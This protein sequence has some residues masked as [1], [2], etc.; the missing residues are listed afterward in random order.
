MKMNVRTPA[1]VLV[2]LGMLSGCATLSG[3]DAK[4]SFKC[5]ASGGISCESASQ[6]YDR[7][8]VGNLPGL[9]KAVSPVG[10]SSVPSKGAAVVAG[11]QAIALPV[12]GSGAGVSTFAASTP[13][14]GMPLRTTQ[15][16]SRIW[17]AP[18]EDSDGH[19]HDQSFIYVTRGESK[20][21]PEHNKRRI[22]EAF[23]PVRSPAQSS[24]KSTLPAKGGT[25]NATGKTIPELAVQQPASLGNDANTFE[26]IK[27]MMGQPK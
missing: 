16:V 13:S 6:I 26:A 4:D 2:M 10:G 9:T 25:D 23:G 22:M 5:P 1:L 17:L 3:L 15:R 14:S 21:L 20:W 12:V 19:L 11:S 27:Q 7:A 8:Q 24:S 18:W